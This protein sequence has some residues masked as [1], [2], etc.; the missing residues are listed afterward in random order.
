MKVSKGDNTTAADPSDRLAVSRAYP[1][2]YGQPLVHLVSEDK[3][4]K[5]STL[6]CANY[7]CLTNLSLGMYIDNQDGF[8]YRSVSLYFLRCC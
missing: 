7:K 5:H 8:A 3:A 1:H 6:R 2:T 4:A